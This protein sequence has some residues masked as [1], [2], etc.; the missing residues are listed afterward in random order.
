[1]VYDSLSVCSLGLGL[2]KLIL[3]DSSK[4][5]V[6]L[7]ISVRDELYL[8]EYMINIKNFFLFNERNISLWERLNKKILDPELI[9]KYEYNF[10]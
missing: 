7:N 2:P 1:M 5:Q 9:Y 8:L 6:A 10:L 4:R 3:T